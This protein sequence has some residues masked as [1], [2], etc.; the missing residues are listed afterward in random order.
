M[1]RPRRRR[2]RKASDGALQV[3][4]CLSMS[5]FHRSSIFLFKR[6]KPSDGVAC[7]RG[8]SVRPGRRDEGTP[9]GG[10]LAP[11]TLETKGQ[12]RAAAW[13][14]RQGTWDVLEWR[15][16]DGVHCGIK[17]APDRA[18]GDFYFW[19]SFDLLICE[20]VLCDSAPGV[21]WCVF[22]ES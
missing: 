7:H 6:R 18:G 2:T 11:P 19:Y 4:F 14:T 22:P 8:R 20:S 13:S 15:C 12:G 3:C 16:A 1:R 9:G 10:G 17:V 21:L 5:L